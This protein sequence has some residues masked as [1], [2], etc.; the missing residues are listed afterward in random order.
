MILE[1][2]RKSGK[3]EN[4]GII[5]LLRR[6]IGNPHLGV[7]L[8]HGVGYTHRDEAEVPKW[9]PSGTPRRS[10][11]VL[12]HNYFSQRAI[13]GFLFLSTSYSYTDDLRTLIND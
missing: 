11:I 13:F 6:S 2:N 7:D 8:R 4:L 12:R 1:K 3:L 9:Y 5:G 10:I